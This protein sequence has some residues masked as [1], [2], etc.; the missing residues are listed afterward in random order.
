M[1]RDDEIKHLG[2]GLIEGFQRLQ[3]G[4]FLYPSAHPSLQKPTEDLLE[5]MSPYLKA[6]GSLSFNILGKE[7][8]LEGVVLTEESITHSA[9]IENCISKGA[10]NFTLMN[11]LKGEELKSFLSFLNA[12]LKTLKDYG[13]L[14]KALAQE[15]IEHIQL[16]E[17]VPLSLER[18]ALVEE[19]KEEGAES[20]KKTYYNT[21][22]C[23]KEAFSQVDKEKPMNVASM[24]SHVEKVVSQL[25]SHKDTFLMLSHIKSFDNYLFHHS[26]NVAIITL[27]LGEKVG[28]ENELLH[29]LGVAALLHDVGKV[30]IPME[31]LD[32]PTALDEREW[33]IM[34]RHPLDGALML[35]NME[36]LEPVVTTVCLEHHARFDLTGY[37]GLKPDTKL[38]PFSLMTALA[39]SYDAITSRR[40]YKE[41]LSVEKAISIMLQEMGKGH[42]PFLTKV[43][44]NIT[45]FYPLGVLVRLNTG[46]IGIVWE[47][48][49]E[50]LLLPKVK[51]LRTSEGEKVKND[52]I[53]DLSE[54]DPATGCYPRFIVSSLNPEEAGIN[55]AEYIS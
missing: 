21:I 37:P 41:A 11:G 27:L 52:H 25:V 30:K 49:Q 8:A 40:Q 28:L 13:S 50:E 35:M 39:D 46:E 15:N 33:T 17:V 44:F 16:E 3:K 18:I 6:N 23:L 55:I 4:L 32:K 10:T 2:Q 12:D 5:A 48:N 24:R 53:V 45:G 1:G 29:S 22:N 51:L 26:V 19:E 14:A 47:R 54:T 7:I 34:K 31:I 38:H 42:E 9:F 20:P 36:A 43:F